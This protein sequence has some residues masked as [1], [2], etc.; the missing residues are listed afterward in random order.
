[1]QLLLTIILDIITPVFILIALG[2]I[3]HRKFILDLSTLS[4]LTTY[5]LLPV[6]GFV[7]IYESRIG[8]EMLLL[9]FV[10]WLCQ[11]LVLISM[12]EVSS[13]VFK[14]DK[15]L[16]STYKNSIVLN[17]SGNFGLPVSQLVFA[18]NSFGQSI[19]ILMMVLQNLLTYTYGLV[20]SIS[21]STT[22]MKEVMKQF[23]KIPILYA[24]LLGLIFNSFSV[25]VPSF[26]WQPI[27]NIT[28][29][30][31]A[32]ALITLGAQSAYIK[33]Q[34]PS[35]PLVLSLIGRLLISPAA[36]LVII[37]LLQLEGTIAQGLFIASAFPSSRNSAS[38]ALEY[39]NYPEYAAQT[40]L[41]STIL[42]SITVTIVVFLSTI[43]F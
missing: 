14:F 25:Q 29:A 33:V 9:I 7:N 31:I 37:Y 40:V 28:N 23:L 12:V 6:I 36:A 11:S 43:L 4:K 24:L 18:G 30:F 22:G 26:V 41:L 15:K 27:E 17:N 5:L 21:A 8:A 39:N 32:V 16:A 34:K 42:S 19:Q 3:L 10:F 38:F 35:L 20:N 2:V 1:M 13:K